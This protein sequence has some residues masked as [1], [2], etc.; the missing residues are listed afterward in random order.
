M[1]TLIFTLGVV[2]CF[3]LNYCLQPTKLVLVHPNFSDVSQSILIV[4]ENPPLT[5]TGRIEWWVN[6]KKVIIANLNKKLDTTRVWS[7]AIYDLGDGFK[8]NNPREM[9]TTSYCFKDLPTQI[10]CIKKN[11]VLGISNIGIK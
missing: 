2:L 7:I 6:N 8:I 3:A 1:K 10:N 4:L 5:R 11:V 9:E